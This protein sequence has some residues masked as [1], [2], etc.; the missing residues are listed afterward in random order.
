MVKLIESQDKISNERYEG[1]TKEDFVHPRVYF[2][3]SNNQ[4]D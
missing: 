2:T 1:K 4:I 3:F